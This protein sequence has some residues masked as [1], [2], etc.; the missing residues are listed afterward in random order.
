MLFFI[1]MFLTCISVNTICKIPSVKNT[2]TLS[3][4]LKHVIMSTNK[5]NKTM[6]GIISEAVLLLQHKKISLRCSTGIPRPWGLSHAIAWTKRFCFLILAD[7]KFCC[8]PF[9]AL[10]V[11][12][13]IIIF[14]LSKRLFKK[15]LLLFSY[16]IY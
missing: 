6:I 13:S 10:R 2:S 9:M 4:R 1:V 8:L 3:R 5:Q 14:F 7:V 11:K 16:K 12:H 15:L